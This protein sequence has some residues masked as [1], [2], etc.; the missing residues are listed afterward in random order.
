MDRL[1]ERL[2]L[3]GGEITP[4][5]NRN[6][7]DHQGADAHPCQPLDRDAGDIHHPADDVVHPLVQRDREHQPVAGFSE[8]AEFV[9]RHSPAV[10]DDPAAHALQHLR[11]WA[12]GRQHVVFLFEPEF[13][14]H[15]PVRQLAVVRQQQQPFGIAVKPA[16]GIEALGR[17]DE[18]H[19]GSALTL[20]A[21]RR[22]VAAWFIE[23]DV[24]AALRPNHL[25][26]D[27]NGVRIGIGFAA[28][29]GDDDAIHGDPAGDDHLL[30]DPARC[31]ATRGKN[32]LDALHAEDASGERARITRG[33]ESGGGCLEHR[34]VGHDRRTGKE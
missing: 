23:H 3:A 26:I 16:D 13:R 14:M 10:D 5:S 34:Q 6:A 8:N 9:R 1:E 20:V 30:G 31:D 21:R 33:R 15:H 7:E 19:H 18:I 12:R 29:L 17:V 25:A 2:L 4:G 24:A 32:A 11:R 27:A 28:K 22:D